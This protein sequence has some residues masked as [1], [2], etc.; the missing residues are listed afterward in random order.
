MFR[1]H[2]LKNLAEEFDNFFGSSNQIYQD[3][4][5]NASRLYKQNKRTNYAKHTLP[6]KGADVWNLLE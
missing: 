2:H 6:N 4:T 1:Y 5:R 3:N